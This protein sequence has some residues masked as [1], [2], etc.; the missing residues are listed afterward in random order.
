MGSYCQTGGSSFGSDWC[1]DPWCYV[2]SSKCQGYATHASSYFEGTTLAFSYS[3][4]DAA[5]GGN[6]WVG[7]PPLA[8][9]PSPSPPPEAT[10]TTDNPCFGR[11]TRVTLAS[12][13]SVLM[14]LLKAGDEV[15]DGVDSS[16]RVVFTQHH[17]ADDTSALLTLTHAEGSLALTPDHVLLLDGRYAP[18][19]SAVIG[20]KLTLAE[21]REAEITAIVAG[22]GGV[23]NAVT[24][25]GKIVASGVLASAHPEW[26]AEWM[27]TSLV[28]LPLSLCNAI[29]YLLPEAAQAYYDALEPLVGAATPSFLAIKRTSSPLSVLLAFALGDLAAALG[30]ATFTLASSPMA[31]AAIAALPLAAYAAR[32]RKA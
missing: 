3:R 16:T 12:G 8:P 30:F 13:E 20:S 9:P 17:L 22:V 18:A 19:R 6:T 11:E 28:P 1:D 23:I 21:G 7:L 10:A 29:S 14:A 31:A 24:A 4:C 15:R 2:D 5:F 26:I 32:P 25:S 27:L